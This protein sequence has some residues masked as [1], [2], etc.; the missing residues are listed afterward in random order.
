MEKKFSIIQRIYTVVWLGLIVYFLFQET[1][2]F[3]PLYIFFI[4]LIVLFGIVALKNYCVNKIRISIIWATVAVA[5]V[6]FV[7]CFTIFY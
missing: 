6:L 3:V 2:F 5:G 4:G 1:F 7:I